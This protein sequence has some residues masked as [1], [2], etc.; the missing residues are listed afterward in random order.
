MYKNFSA[1]STESLDS[2]FNRL[3]KIRKKPDLDTMSFDDLYNNFKIVK[4]EVKRTANSSSSLNSQNM[5]FVSSPSSTNEVNTA[6]RVS[7]AN[8]QANPASTQVNNSSTQVSTTN[9]SDA[10]VKII[11]NGN[12]T[13]GYDKSKVEC[14]NC[15]T[16]RHFARECR[17]P[18]N[19]D[20]RNR[21]QDSSKRIVNVEE[22]PPKA[23]FAIDGQYDD[24]RIEFNK[25]E[26]NLA[27]YKRGLAYVEEQLVF[28]K[29]NE[30]KDAKSLLAVYKQDLVASEDY[31]VQIHEDD[32]EKID[33]KWQLALL[34]MRTRR[35]FQKT[36]RKIIIN[37]N[38]TAGYD[39]SKVECF[40]CHTIRHFARECRQPMNQDSRNRNQDSSKRIVNVEETPP[41]AM[42][43]IDGVGF[44]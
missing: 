39:K 25:S 26:F 37:G 16:I 35:F 38:D 27:T 34:S 3:Q 36:G 17:Q 31:L 1:P 18:M 40:N 6:Y 41:K 23:M 12:D 42:F 22:T 5:A 2:I 9:L 33:L 21:N 4:Q 7:N 29:K 32:L 8:T 43:A 13:A 11:I 10:T 28:Y 19:Q 44:D 14:F 20:S 30:Y 15:H 24:L